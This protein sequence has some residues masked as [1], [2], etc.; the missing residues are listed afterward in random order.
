MDASVSTGEISAQR[1]AKRDDQE[2]RSGHENTTVIE[3]QRGAISKAS[4]TR[5][6]SSQDQQASHIVNPTTT[7][8]QDNNE[9]ISQGQN[10][11][12]AG[13][14][15]PMSLDVS[16]VP[17]PNDTSTN[18]SNTQRSIHKIATQVLG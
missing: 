4:P 16:Q 17:P 14:H 9:E 11:V 3:P 8:L 7:S 1:G 15:Y 13:A 5:P 6:V 2:S 10:A 18:P 12:Q